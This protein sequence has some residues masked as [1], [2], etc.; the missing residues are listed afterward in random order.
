MPNAAPMKISAQ[1]LTRYKELAEKAMNKARSVREQ[2]EKVVEQATE[3]AVT[4]G[5]AFALGVAQGKTGGI[6][7]MGAPLDLLVG[8]GAHVAGFM[9]L[10]GK[11]SHHLHAV[12]NGALA[13]YAGTMGRAIGVNWKT[14]GKLGLPA[15]G[16]K[17]AGELPEGMSG[18]DQLSDADLAAAVLRR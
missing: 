13:L 18:S 14:T 7:I 17:S 11:A 5:T 3:T 12:G 9:K 2:G 16:F 15:G 4:A 8:A 1:A 6:E 10:G